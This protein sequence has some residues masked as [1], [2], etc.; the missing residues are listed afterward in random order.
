MDIRPLGNSAQSLATT[1]IDRSTP[2]TGTAAVPAQ[3]VAASVEAASTVQQPAS[4]PDLEQV[5][6][7]VQKIN[8]M[9]QSL[10]NGL[11]FAIDEDSD[12]TIIKVVDQ[13]TKEVIRQVPSK[14]V[15]EIGKAL[16]RAQGLLIRQKA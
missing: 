7:A 8:K 10:S 3:P 15:L 1:H 5:K 14:E 9:L 2:P 16:D 12:R 6:E 4:L 13:E 11:E